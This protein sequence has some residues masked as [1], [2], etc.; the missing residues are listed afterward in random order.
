MGHVDDAA[1]GGAGSAVTEGANLDAVGAGNEVPGL[2]GLLHDG[3]GLVEG[4]DGGGV[5]SVGDKVTL[6]DGTGL[7][8]VEGATVVLA[9]EETLHIDEPGRRGIVDGDVG[10]GEVSAVSHFC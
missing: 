4:R 8:V 10:H 1:L 6:S 9:G 7:A 3:S 5:G 2:R